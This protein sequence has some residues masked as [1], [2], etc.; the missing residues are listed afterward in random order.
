M[1]IW[2]LFIVKS[3]INL[4]DVISIKNVIEKCIVFQFINKSIW[5]ITCTVI[6]VCLENF[7]S[8]QSVCLYWPTCSTDSHFC[9]YLYFFII[10]CAYFCKEISV[11]D[12]FMTEQACNFTKCNGRFLVWPYLAPQSWNPYCRYSSIFDYRQA[13][14]ILIFS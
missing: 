4:R 14:Y 9:P 13:K 7:E 2:F 6:T 3:I 1:T 8:L 11:H 5:S 12:L 10:T